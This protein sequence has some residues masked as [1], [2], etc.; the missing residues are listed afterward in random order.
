[1]ST[2]EAAQILR[3]DEYI[4]WD[5]L[6]IHFREFGTI[7]TLLWKDLVSIK[8]IQNKPGATY[9]DTTLRLDTW[10]HKHFEIPLKVLASQKQ[11][12]DLVTAA[13]TNSTATVYGLEKLPQMTQ[14]DIIQLWSDGSGANYKQNKAILSGV[15]ILFAA[16]WMVALTMAM[17]SDAAHLLHGNAYIIIQLL[18]LLPLAFIP[19]YGRLLPVNRFRLGDSEF[20]AEATIGTSN[21]VKKKI[22]WT[23]IDRVEIS[24][25]TE[26]QRGLHRSVKL[27]L[28]NGS[29]YAIPLEMIGTSDNWHRMY[30]ALAAHQNIALGTVTADLFDRINPDQ[31]DPGYTQL[32]LDSLLAPARRERLIPLAVNSSLRQGEYILDHKLGTGGQGSAYLAKN[33]DGQNVV[34]KEYILPVYVDAK[35]RKKA[36]SQFENE[37]K[38][39]ERL[40]SP[41]IVK[42]LDFFI[43]DHRAY[44]VLENIEGHNLREM[45]SSSGIFSETQAIECALSMSEA[46]EY[47]HGQTPPIIHRDFS[48]ENVMLCANGKVKV[49][50][51]MVAQQNE[52]SITAAVVGKRAYLPPEQFR[53]DATRQS[54]IYALGGILFFLLTGKDPEPLTPSHPILSNDTISGALDELIA[55][56]TAY[57]TAERIRDASDFKSQLEAI[58]R[59]ESDSGD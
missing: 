48:P 50:D 44:L 54:D 8:F 35:V 9:Q 26:Q 5:D 16:G 45:V 10:L 14:K 20:T 53:G 24:G 34:L 46:L 57:D 17:H 13:K 25:E 11:F 33:K 51:F 7:Q 42:L 18:K 31:D 4:R 21:V 32:W 36:V 43:E 52:E 41:L 29:S 15:I 37:A 49:I 47:L 38:I 1:M 23:A 59:A 58:R 3:W 56:A 55:K 2:E 28:K 12:E 6:A 22:A 19:I 30:S 40:D 27:I 39:L